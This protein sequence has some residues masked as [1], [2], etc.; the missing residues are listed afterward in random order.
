MCGFG[1]SRRHGSVLSTVINRLILCRIA[2]SFAW[3]P[4]C[5]WDNQGAQR[6]DWTMEADGLAIQQAWAQSVAHLLGWGIL[7]WA[8]VVATV[9]LLMLVTVR[10]VLRRRQFWCT[11]AQRTVEVEFV[12]E[13]G[14]FGLQRSVAVRSCSVF[15]PPMDVRCSRR[16]I[17]S[18]V[19]M[20]LSAKPLSEWRTP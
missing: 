20:P 1:A 7:A 9:L 12:E 2:S 8:M 17:N 4:V 19:R 18:E 14:V 15:E 10:R 13:E 16:C 3:H 6:M 5:S 11:E